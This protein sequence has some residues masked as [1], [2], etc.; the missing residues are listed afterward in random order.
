MHRPS[1]IPPYSSIPSFS[2]TASGPLT[3]IAHSRE[4]R[5][6][7]RPP[8]PWGALRG[9]T[10]RPASAPPALAV[11]VPAVAQTLRRGVPC[12]RGRAGAAQ[13]GARADLPPRPH[14]SPGQGRRRRS[15][16]R[17]GGGRSARR[18]SS[19]SGCCCWTGPRPSSSSCSSPPSASAA[20]T[21][22]TCPSSSGT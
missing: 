4:S 16:H 12:T 5:P 21:T 10:T 11:A 3:Y 14:K 6:R 15:R 20:F 9:G 1:R 17:R 2:A 18:P 22:T 7:R 8:S 13:T 19:P